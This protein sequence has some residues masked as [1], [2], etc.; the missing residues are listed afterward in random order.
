MFPNFV[1]SGEP[2]RAAWANDVVRTLRSMSKRAKSKK[3]FTVAATDSAPCPFGEITRSEGETYIRGGPLLCGDKNFNVGDYE[4][5][6]ETDGTWL[7]SIKLDCECNRDD[8]GEIILGGI[9]T[10]DDTPAWHKKAW[11][12][13]TSY[14]DNTSPD[15]SDGI[16]SI[17]IPIGKLAVESGSASFEP[18]A[19]GFIT[20]GQCDGTFSHT[21]G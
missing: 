21:R 2:L 5:D 20:I 15:V 17:V 9:K 16:G 8:D 1:K 11:T 12:D 10:S 4:L 14:D 13:G 18:V 6:L 19:C 3:G 7:V